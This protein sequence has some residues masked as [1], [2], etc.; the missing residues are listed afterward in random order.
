KQAADG[1]NGAAAATGWQAVAGGSCFEVRARSDPRGRGDDS[2]AAVAYVGL[3]GFLA[4]GLRT[5]ADAETHLAAR[6][7]RSL[8]EAASGLRS[9]HE[10]AI[11]QHQLRNRS[12]DRGKGERHAVLPDQ[13]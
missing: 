12:A 8:G 5:T 2:R 7:S 6:D 11:Q 1:R 4:A 13:R 3:S 9:G 10:M